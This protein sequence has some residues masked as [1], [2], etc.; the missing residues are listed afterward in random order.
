MTEKQAESRLSAL[1][2]SEMKRIIRMSTIPR[3]K[4]LNSKAD[5]SSEG[6]KSANPSTLGNS[7][8][9]HKIPKRRVVKA[10]RVRKVA[11]KSPKKEDKDPEVDPLGTPKP[12]EVDPG[13]DSTPN[14]SIRQE[15]QDEIPS[16]D[17]I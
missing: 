17:H 14:L 7:R 13:M 2:V 12:F 16:Q 9:I 5:L 11:K 3:P 4:S 6:D 1:K 10:P 8:S 15:S